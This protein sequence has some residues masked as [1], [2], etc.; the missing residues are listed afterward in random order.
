MEPEAVST[1]YHWSLVMPS[2][3]IS[4]PVTVSITFTWVSRYKVAT[5]SEEVVGSL[6]RR[7]PLPVT[8]PLNSL[9]EGT[10]S[11][12]SIMSWVLSSPS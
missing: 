3:V 9:S 8:R 12:P 5:V 6:R 1:W 7:T 11:P 4:W 2:A 10:S